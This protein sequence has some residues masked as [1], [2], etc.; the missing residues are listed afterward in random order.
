MSK[1]AIGTKEYRAVKIELRAIAADPAVSTSVPCIEGYAAKFNEVYTHG[2]PR[3]DMRETIRPGAFTRA[4]AEKHDVKCLFNHDDNIVLGRTTNGTLTMV[5]DNVGLK[6]HCDVAPTNA[7]R[8]VHAL[9][10]RGDVDGCSF[11]FV[12]TKQKVTRNS[13]GSVD[14]DVLDVDLLDVSPVLNPA[15]DSTSVEA[16][17]ADEAA[18]ELLSKNS[19]NKSGCKC[20]CENCVG[21]NCEECTDADCTDPDCEKASRSRK[22]TADEVATLRLKVELRSKNS[23]N[24]NGCKCPCPECT[25]DNCEDCSNSDCEDPDCT[26][27]AE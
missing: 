22:L 8:D 17:S 7:A 21:D 12:V 16:R 13:D 2:G 5:Q 3:G 11:G 15:F 27:P 24:D 9:V 18:K 26:E 20:P 10:T 14:R 25:A 19:A 1:A 23:A 4:L 6:F